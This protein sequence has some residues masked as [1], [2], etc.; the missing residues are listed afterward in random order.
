MQ[1][2][3]PAFLFGYLT[4]SCAQA[5]VLWQDTSISL[6][7]GN[8]YE[9]DDHTR[10]VV[11]LEHASGHSWGDNFFFMDRFRDADGDVATYAELGPRFSLGKLSGKSFAAGPLQDVLIATQWE[12]SGIAD[13]YLL[14]LG[15]SFDLPGFK[16]FQANLYERF[17]DDAAMHNNQQLTLVWALPFNIAGQ[18]FLLDG[19][20]DYTN[21]PGKGYS[22]S[23][24]LTPQLKWNISRYLQQK[25]PVYIGIEYVYW[26]N[27]YNLADSS[28][29]TTNE[30][31]LNWLFKMHF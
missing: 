23:M 22:S 27:K 25:S 8:Q 26:N 4:C 6:L 18:A 19:F 28:A 24:N 30:R 12:M 9:I 29:L 17:N 13:N 16:Y 21:S 20:M 31:N 1:K 10:S 3:I 11:T 15:T 7:S 14:G 2:L 5:E